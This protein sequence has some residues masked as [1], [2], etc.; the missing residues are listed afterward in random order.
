MTLGAVRVMGAGVVVMIL[1]MKAIVGIVVMIYAEK[2][3]ISDHTDVSSLYNMSYTG[4]LLRISKLF[5]I[6]RHVHQLARY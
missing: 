4:L 3:T 2:V 1:M 6:C 5:V